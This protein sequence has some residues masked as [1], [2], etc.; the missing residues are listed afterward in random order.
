MSSISALERRVT[1]M[2]AVHAPRRQMVT[3][4]I[5][6]DASPEER[7]AKRQAR[8]EALGLTEDQVELFVFCRWFS[9]GEPNPPHAI[10]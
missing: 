5:R 10:A 4:W 1:E 2:E 6:A 3:C 9:E 7:E 8:L